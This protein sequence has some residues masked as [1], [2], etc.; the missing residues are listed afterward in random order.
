MT[1]P[2]TAA[3]PSA[4]VDSALVKA[5]AIPSHKIARHVENLRR[6]NPNASPQDIIDI[7]SS[8]LR[9]L[10]TSTGGAVGATAAVPGVGSA[11]ALALT[12]ADMAAFFSAAGF[13]SLAIAEVHGV[14]I[15][16]AQRRK[17]LL[18]ASVLGESGAKSVANLSTGSMTHWAKALGTTIPTSSIKQVN[19]VLSSRFVK[20]H[21]FRQSGVVMGRLVPF[22]IG[23]VVGVIGGRALAHTVINQTSKAFGPAP[24]RF[25]TEVSFDVAGRH[26]DAGALDAADL[27]SLVIGKSPEQ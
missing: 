13:Y 17:T 5:T 14:Q 20:R 21:I 23:A 10:L 18:L 3:G 6:R 26:A 1:Y 16:D 22:G 8:E 27:R 2:P 19:R 9:V 12:A 25:V 15:D 11:T 4:L 24:Q 7:L